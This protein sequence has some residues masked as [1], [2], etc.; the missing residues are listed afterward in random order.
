MV[1]YNSAQNKMQRKPC[2]EGVKPSRER[3]IEGMGR[4]AW[5]QVRPGLCQ[6]CAGGGDSGLWCAAVLFLRQ[7]SKSDEETGFQSGGHGPT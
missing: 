2:R 4:G 5:C 6:I 3:V 7:T 1:G